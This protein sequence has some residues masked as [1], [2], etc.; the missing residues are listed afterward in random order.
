MHTELPPISEECK[1]PLSDGKVAIFPTRPPNQ[2][3]ELLAK[4]R[5]ETD[6]YEFAKLALMPPLEYERIR[7][8]KAKQLGCRPS[9]LDR[10]VERI[11]AAIGDFEHRHPEH[12][13]RG[14]ATRGRL[15]DDER[16]FTSFVLATS[17]EEVRGEMR[18]VDLHLL[19][20]GELSVCTGVPCD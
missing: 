4:T 17:A 5:T 10:H 3:A 1:S 8:E 7:L 16:P 12:Y 6:A 9:F 19:A 15:W 14:T 13:E 20:D 18:T 2:N 11:R